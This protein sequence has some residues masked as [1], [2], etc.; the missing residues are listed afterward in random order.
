MT[1]PGKKT[2]SVFMVACVGVRLQPIEAY[3]YEDAVKKADER[4]DWGSIF[5]ARAIR[6]KKVFHVNGWWQE[7]HVAMVGR[8]EDE[9]EKHFTYSRKMGWMEDKFE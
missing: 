3:S 6:S 8:P 5:P 4:T 7:N 1:E 2:Y 9:D